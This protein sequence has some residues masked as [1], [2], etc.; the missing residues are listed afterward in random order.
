MSNSRP[1]FLKMIRA[2]FLSS[3]IFPLSAG[4]LLSFYVTGIIDV[5]NLLL[6]FIMGICLHIATNV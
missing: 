2:P 3:I 6:V 1:D 5:P 4:S